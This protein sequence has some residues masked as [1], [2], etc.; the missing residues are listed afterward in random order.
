METTRHAP[1]HK[2]LPSKSVAT[3]G[4]LSATLDSRKRKRGALQDISNNA[5]TRGVAAAKKPAIGSGLTKPATTKTAPR[6]NKRTNTTTT[7]TGAAKRSVKPAV[8][9]R[10]VDG[11]A[12]KKRKHDGDENAPHHKVQTSLLS[13]QS[14]APAATKTARLTRSATKKAKS[15]STTTTE[16]VDVKI[17]AE[18]EAVDIECNETIEPDTTQPTQ[19]SITP[20]VKEEPQPLRRTEIPSYVRRPYKFRFDHKDSGFDEE[21]YR[22]QICD[23]D[24]LLQGSAVNCPKIARDVARYHS[25]HEEKYMPK[26]TYIG[27]IQQDINEKMRT[28]LV[29]WLIEVGEEYELDS[30]TFHKAV[31]LVDRCLAKFKINRKQFQLLG[32]ACMMIAAKYE[33]VYGPNVDEFVYIS[34]QTYTSEEMLEMESKVLQTLEYRIGATTCHGFISRFVSAGCETDKQKILVKYLCDFT[35]LYYHMLKYRPSQMVAAAIYLARLMTDEKQAW[36][37]TLHHVT[38]YSAWDIKNCVLDLFQL[39]RTENDVVQNHRDK[40][41]AVTEKYLAEKLHAVAAIAP[42]DQAELA[43]SFLAFLPPAST[44]GSST[45]SNSS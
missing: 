8:P 17:K 27:D 7:T 14:I 3:A 12:A 43:K 38:G 11:G 39:H 41:K 28:I 35:L 34:D 22:T 40:V 30:L 29:D 25:H 44:S 16:G 15:Q 6:G 4:K 23:V 26:P 19:Q 18:A 20:E 2:S 33:E 13:F 31:N 10:R 42:V 9:S 24:A 37:P 1:Q 21:T 5:T 36:T 32:C 45:S